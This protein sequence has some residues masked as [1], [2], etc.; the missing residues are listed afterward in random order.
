M[1]K[2]ESDIVV[3]WV[4]YHGTIFGFNNLYIIDNYST[5]GTFEKLLKLKPM[6]IHLSRKSDYRKKGEYM[7]WYYYKCCAPEDIAY[8]ID[9][10]EF[11]VYYDKNTNNI[12]TDK[13]TILNYLHN[14]PKSVIYKTN[15]INATPN[16]E[17]PNGFSRA[18]TDCNRGLYDNYNN[19][20]KSFMKKKFYNGPI[21][22][23]NHIPIKNYYMTDLCLVHFHARNMEQY[24]KKVYNNVKGFNYPADNLANLHELLKRDPGCPG[25]HHVKNQI[26]ILENTLQLP[27][28]H[29]SPGGGVDLTPLND[30]IKQIDHK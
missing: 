17:A 29:Y 5:D 19:H 30:F 7:T 25:H 6:G 13:H 1:V 20:A 4:F 8:P 16:Q 12:S 22:H 28:H 11:I 2:D 14:L 3:D 23:G 27:C 15:Y 18:P 24:K 21:D 9:I 10:D 26:N